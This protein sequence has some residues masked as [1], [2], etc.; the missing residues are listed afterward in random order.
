[1]MRRPRREGIL[2]LTFGLWY[3]V[4]RIVEDSL[5]IDKRFFGLTGSQWTALGGRHDLRGDCSCG[6]PFAPTPMRRAAG[7]PRAADRGGSSDRKPAVGPESGRAAWM[8]RP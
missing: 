1:M 3:G 4:S 2:T 8:E 7:G 6:S 5:R